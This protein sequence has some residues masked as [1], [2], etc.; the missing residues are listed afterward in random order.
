MFFSGEHGVQLNMQAEE[1]EYYL[2]MFETTV[3]TGDMGET[4]DKCFLKTREK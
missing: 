2:Y 3:Q 4:G 1:H